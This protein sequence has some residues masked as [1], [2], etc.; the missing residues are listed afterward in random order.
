MKK[1]EILKRQVSSNGSYAYYVLSLA[2]AAT[3]ALNY[4]SRECHSTIVAA[5]RDI[6]H[7]PFPSTMGVYADVDGSL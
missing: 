4:G 2:A 6:R 7:V 3:H 1:S 5:P